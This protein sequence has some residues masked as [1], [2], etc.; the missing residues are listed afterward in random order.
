MT[1][2]YETIL[3]TLVPSFPWV[4]FFPRKYGDSSKQQVMARVCKEDKNMPLTIVLSLT[5][6]EMPLQH[7]TPSQAPA[8]GQVHRGV[9]SH[10]TPPLLLLELILVA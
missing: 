6:P 2:I 1:N 4:P 8:G 10:V 3:Q 5:H 7:G 9:F